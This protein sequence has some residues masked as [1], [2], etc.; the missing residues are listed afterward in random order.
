M[1]VITGLSTW[2]NYGSKLSDNLAQ[3]MFSGHKMRFNGVVFIKIR[4]IDG[5]ESVILRL[6]FEFRVK[7][8]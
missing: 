8:D 7:T 3:Y 5:L 4:V 6:G 2:E 1:H